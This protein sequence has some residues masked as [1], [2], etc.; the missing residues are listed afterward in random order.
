ME[1][2]IIHRDRYDDW[3]LPKGKRDEGETDL[4]CAKREVFEETGFTGVVGEELPSS[5]YSVRPKKSKKGDKR[6][7]KIVRWWLMEMTGG[8]F[9]PNEEVD[10]IQWVSPS[11]AGELLTY[12]R[13]QDLLLGIDFAELEQSLN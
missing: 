11:K 12:Q 2:L 4:E 13:D 1:L 8:T 7:P 10:S 9:E 5:E 6:V 3:T